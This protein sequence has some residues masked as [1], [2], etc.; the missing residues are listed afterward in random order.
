MDRCSPVAP[1][2]FS[3]ESQIDIRVRAHSTNS[4]PGGAR[5]TG[6]DALDESIAFVAFLDSDDIW[7][8]DHL[9]VALRAL[10]AGGTFFFAN[11]LQLRTDVPAFERAGRIR[12]AEHVHL[13][14]DCYQYQGSM[15]DQIY[16]GNVIGTPTVVYDFKRHRTLRFDPNYRRAGED[17][18]MWSS[19]AVDGATLFSIIAVSEVLR[20]G[21]RLLGRS[22]GFA[23]IPRAHRRRDRLPSLCH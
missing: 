6:L 21:E 12:P 8:P 15:L 5:N 16:L 2:L 3:L 4:G 19:L 9:D 13:F 23:R 1:E 22:V 7:M 20:R 11:F 18:L 10:A 17:Y 14:N